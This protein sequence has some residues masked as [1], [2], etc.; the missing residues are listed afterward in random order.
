MKAG[1]LAPLPAAGL[2]HLSL[3]A[4]RRGLREVTHYRG[5]RGQSCRRK[6][7]CILGTL[8]RGH[9]GPTGQR[10]RLMKESTHSISSGVGL[11]LCF[12]FYKI[13]VGSHRCREQGAGMS[14]MQAVIAVPHMWKR[15]WLA[16]V[17]VPYV[18]GTN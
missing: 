18:A 7:G 11:G 1:C 9:Q 14:C 3:E 6:C 4:N 10:E 16:V 17:D 2:W 12:P 13:G 15:H 8:L 5:R